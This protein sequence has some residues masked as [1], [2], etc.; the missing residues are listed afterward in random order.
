[1]IR[2]PVVA[3]Q[4]YPGDKTSLFKMLKGFFK[5]GEAVRDMKAAVVPHAGYEYSGKVAGSLYS[6]CSKKIETAIIIGPNHTG[7]GSSYSI[8]KSG[9]WRTPLGDVSIDEEITAQISKNAEILEEDFEAQRGEHSIEVQ[10]P[11]LQYINPKI[12]I[13]PMVF[14]AHS[15]KNL[16]IIANSIA[17]AVKGSPKKILVIASSDLTHYEEKSVAREKDK[18]AIEA[19][20]ALDDELLIENVR[21]YSITMCGVAPCYVIVSFA[22]KMGCKT[23][24]LIAY[25][26]SAEVSGD[27]SAVVGY[28]SI[29]LY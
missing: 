19:I 8:M 24:K 28:A 10:L 22:S 9:I 23:G 6:V 20:V 14:A 1:M 13:V 16:D 12:K 17:L 27:Y 26:T 15:L 29:A 18:K 11:F 2:K 25:Q 3:G 4:F 21:Q 7:V 5:N